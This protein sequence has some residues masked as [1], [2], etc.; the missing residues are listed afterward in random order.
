MNTGH[1]QYTH[2]S[3]YALGRNIITEPPAEDTTFCHFSITLGGCS[4]RFTLSRYLYDIV[5]LSS[6]TALPEY[7]ALS[8]F[9]NLAYRKTLVPNP[10]RTVLFFSSDAAVSS[11]DIFVR[12]KLREF[13]QE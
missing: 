4:T 7:H 1:A 12:K 11:Q 2:A 9:N 3:T 13:D 5:L 6:A 8:Q 10:G